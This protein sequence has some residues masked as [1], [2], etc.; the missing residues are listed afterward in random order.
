[1]AHLREETAMA[2]EVISS[3]VIRAR[4]RSDESIVDEIYQELQF[5]DRTNQ[6]SPVVVVKVETVGLD[7]GEYMF[8]WVF[9]LADD[10]GYWLT[11]H[12]YEFDADNGVE[13]LALRF[14]AKEA[15]EY[16]S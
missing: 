10:E 16:V 14:E 15:E 12:T 8:L 6:A 2:D 3:R 9:D 5:L 4:Y 1:M 7:F 11:T 13:V